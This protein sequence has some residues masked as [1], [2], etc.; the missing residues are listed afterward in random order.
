[1]TC[2]MYLPL[3]D[4]SKPFVVSGV[5]PRLII[6]LGE[7]SSVDVVGSVDTMWSASLET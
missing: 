6:G 1:M 4:D 2:I 7:C 5:S 3:S